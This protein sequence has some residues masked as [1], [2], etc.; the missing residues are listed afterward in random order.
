[1]ATTEAIE[2]EL[3]ELVPHLRAFARTFHRDPSRADDLVQETILKAWENAEKFQEGT[4]IRAWAFTILRNTF[5]SER[6]KLGREVEDVDEVFSAT[7]AEQPVHDDRMQ[8]Q[9]FKEALNQLS[10]DHREALVLVGAAGF[11]YE[12]VAEM[13]G[14]KLGTV[15]SRVNRARA[16][17]AEL[18][19]IDDDQLGSEL[20]GTSD[21]QSAAVQ[22]ARH[23]RLIA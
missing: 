2:A 18:M 8:F 3:V 10:D 15:K 11:S 22:Q 13:C 1:M 23:R 17:L 4:S 12:E 6:R 20:A 14:C 21:V 5:L 16:R 7:L 9:D 19:R